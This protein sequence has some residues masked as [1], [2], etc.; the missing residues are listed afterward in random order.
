LL[1]SNPNVKLPKTA[2]W[3]DIWILVFEIDLE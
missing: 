1:K 2:L 3:A